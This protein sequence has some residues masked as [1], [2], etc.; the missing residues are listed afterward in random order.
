MDI[1][2]WDE[3]P[4][5][6]GYFV[7][8]MGRIRTRNLRRTKNKD[9][10]I[11]PYHKSCRGTLNTLQVRLRKGGLSHSLSLHRL[12]LATF[13]GP[14]PS[15]MEGCHND[16]DVTNNSLT[17]LRWDTPLSNQR[18]K[19]KHGTMARGERNGRAKITGALAEKIKNGEFGGMSQREFARRIGVNR[20]VITRIRSGE[21]WSHPIREM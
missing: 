17:N 11:D 19:H 12:I 16:G 20:S 1:E 9:G 13:I 15:G 18:D 14:C 2:I 5:Y 4:G 10:F 3:I 6:P 7:S 8:T 21:N